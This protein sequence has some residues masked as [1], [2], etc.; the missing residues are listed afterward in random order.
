M[1]QLLITLT[2]VLIASGT[3]QAALHLKS[4]AAAGEA[5][6]ETF[7]RVADVMGRVA[8]ADAIVTVTYISLR[9]EK[10]EVH[11]RLVDA[12]SARILAT[13]SETIHVDWETDY[14]SQS[15]GDVWDTP[16]PP[17]S[18]APTERIGGFT[19]PAWADLRDALNRAPRP[20]CDERKTQPAQSKESPLSPSERI[21]LTRAE[22]EIWSTLREC[23]K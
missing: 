22:K 15:S 5:S 23:Y 17:I 14:F 2:A 21:E 9:K 1:K 8:G 3:S 13:E 4:A 20:D 11:F 7:E 10:L 6:A 19:A 16:P 12:E 18:F